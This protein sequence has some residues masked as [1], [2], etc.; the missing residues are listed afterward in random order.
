MHTTPSISEISMMD[1][2]IHSSHTRTIIKLSSAKNTGKFPLIKTWEIPRYSP[3]PC[4]AQRIKP[5]KAWECSHLHPLITERE[6]LSIPLW[7]VTGIRHPLECVSSSK[8]ILRAV[9]FRPRQQTLCSASPWLETSSSG[10]A[11]WRWQPNETRL[12]DEEVYGECACVSMCICKRGLW[13]FIPL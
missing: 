12:S 6:D 5:V 10:T 8:W 9:N 2:A 4:H 13:L 3:L 11:H 7:Q 1:R